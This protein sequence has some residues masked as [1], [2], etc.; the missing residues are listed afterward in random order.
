MGVVG[1]LP[2]QEGFGL[3]G[4]AFVRLHRELEPGAAAWRTIPWETDL[5]V[6]QRVAAKGRKPLFIWA[7]DGHPLGCT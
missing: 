2:G 3:D 5:V 4:D 1:F 7:M 6:A